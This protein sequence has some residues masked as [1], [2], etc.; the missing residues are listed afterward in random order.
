MPVA[1]RTR[2][3]NPARVTRKT[4]RTLGGSSQVAKVVAEWANQFDA[5]LSRLTERQD[6]FLRSL[7]PSS[8]L[9]D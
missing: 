6:A 3:T 5:K 4:T 1:Q 9:Q 2:K 8:A 7:E